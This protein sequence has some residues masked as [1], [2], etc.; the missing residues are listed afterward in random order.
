MKILKLCAGLC[1]ASL[2]TACG[3]IP[4]NTSRSAP[5]EISF[6]HIEPQG[7]ALKEAPNTL[8][9]SVTA[10]HVNVPQSLTVSEAGNLD[11]TA[12][13]VWA[14]DSL[15]DHRAEVKAIVESAFYRGTS[16]MIGATALTLD[17]DLLRFH[18]VADADR[19]TAGSD[20][21]ITFNLTVRRTSTGEPLA[22]ARR[23][24]AKL[25]AGPI[26]MPFGETAVEASRTG[27]NQNDL[28]IDHLTQVIR[29]ESSRFVIG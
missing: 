26:L 18:S 19:P 11:Q 14:G 4:D 23:V 2:I 28:V 24:E 21:T 27:A 15:G 1:L 3:Q 9:F 29:D 5:F 13:I 8:P 7:F 17:V 6:N 16:D 10:I 20:H 25:D 22:P 12:D